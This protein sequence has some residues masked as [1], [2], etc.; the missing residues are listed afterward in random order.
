M[1]LIEEAARLYLLGR[2]THAVEAWSQADA[3]PGAA[4]VIPLPAEAYCVTSADYLA[5]QAREGL[6]AAIPDAV[7]DRANDP[8][9]I[10]R[11]H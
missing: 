11:A 3:V 7:Q 4:L 2:D 10:P 6:V 1:R 8:R 9:R 5:S